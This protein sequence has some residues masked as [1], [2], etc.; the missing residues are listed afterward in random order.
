MRN[1]ILREFSLFA[2]LSKI[3][4]PFAVTISA[5][6]GYLVFK[7]MLDL[8][9]FF[10][11]GGVFLLSAGSAALNQFQ[12][13]RFDAIMHRTRKRPIPSGRFSVKGTLIFSIIMALSGITILYFGTNYIATIIG[14][15]TL[16]WYNAV[17]TPL[18]RKTVFAILAGAFVGAFPPLIG[19][20]AAGGFVFDPEI[21]LISA[22]LFIWQVPHFILLLLKYGNDYEIAGFASLTTIFTEKGLKQLIF[23]WILATACAV[24]II[25]VA[26]VISSKTITIALLLTSVWLV[27]SFYFILKK[28]SIN[29]KIAFM[30]LNIFL[31]LV[32]ILFSVD[33]LI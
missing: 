17:Y 27:T 29:L 25:P 24:V 14:L 31:L 2:E 30:Q 5:L 3:K 4:I 13:Y 15:I 6:T 21:L 11:M 12:E 32:L 10:L 7:E 26:G 33:S 19:W 18:K 28:Q 16:F 9:A 8:T 22:L 23:I 20:T 1:K